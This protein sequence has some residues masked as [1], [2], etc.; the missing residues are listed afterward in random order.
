ML[1]KLKKILT[2]AFL[3]FNIFSISLVIIYRFVPIP[4]T[5]LML[6]RCVQQ[7]FQNERHIRLSKDWTSFDKINDDIKLAVICSEDQNFIE[8]SGFDFEAIEKAIKRNKKSKKTYG[9]ST[10]SQQTAKNVF[11]FPSRSWLRKGLEV[12]FTF[13]IE[14]CWSKQRILE[15]YINVAELGDG[16]YGF[17]KASEVYFKTNQARITRNQ[18]ALLATLL[19]SPLKYSAVKPSPYV[20]RQQRWIVRQM[21]VYESYTNYSKA[22]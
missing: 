2:K 22:E 20:S 5:P 13:L 6:I 17:P 7:A 14:I 9:A 11:L 4:I 21:N 19:P 10:I 16:I 12:Y 8:H 3:Y 15:V 18:V 1:N